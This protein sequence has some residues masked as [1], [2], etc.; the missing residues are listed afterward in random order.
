VGGGAERIAAALA[1]PP[2]AFGEARVS[3]D[4][5]AAIAGGWLEFARASIP[6]GAE[7]T[8]LPMNNHPLTVALFFA[9]SSLPLP[10]AILAPDARAWRTSPPLPANTPVFVAPPLRALAA[11][12]EAAG[13]AARVVPD[14]RPASP[15]ASTSFLACPGFVNFTSGSTGLPK[16]VYITTRSFLIQT[17]AIVE[18]SALAPGDAVLATL[19]LSTHYGLGQALILPTVLGSPVGLVERF[20]HRSAFRLLDAA[21]YAYWAATPL[22]ADVLARAPLAGPCPAAPAICHISAGRLSPRT[23]RSFAE[24]FGVTLA[25][26]YGQTENGFIAVDTGSPTAIRPD[27]VG[28]PAPGI[29]IRVGDDPRH[30]LPPGALGRVW[31]KSPWYMEGYGFPPRLAPRE[32]RDGWWPTADMGFLDEGGY[33]AL[34][35]RADDCFKT[36]L[37]H[38]VNP[39]MIADA[40]AAHPAVTDVLVVP[41]GEAGAALIGALV[42]GESVRAGDLRAA[43]ASALPPWLQPHVLAVTSRLPRLP[44]GK[45]DREACAA[46]LREARGGAAPVPA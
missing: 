27:R 24:R 12:A 20:D 38:L 32:G 10:V 19:P 40:L 41:I 21:P 1:P 39:G 35:G 2:I 30:P 31:Y 16:P 25:P 17:A 15:P 34:A 28:R 29:E 7:L 6:P 18:A 42:E 36:G 13:L 3:S 23:F 43:V 9:L 44:G 14:A 46:L 33:L 37:G 5:L 22:M 45:P 4:E 11:A 26:S 8:A